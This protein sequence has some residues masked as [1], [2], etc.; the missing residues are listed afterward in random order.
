MSEGIVI[1]EVVD[2]HHFDISKGLVF[3]D[4]PENIPANAA[5]TVYANTHCHFVSPFVFPS[6]LQ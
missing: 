4:G 6:C 1:S 2:G 5:K 3:T